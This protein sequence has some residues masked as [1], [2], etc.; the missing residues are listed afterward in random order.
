MKREGSIARTFDSTRRVMLLNHNDDSIREKAQALFGDV[1]SDRQGVVDYFKPA[2][3]LKGDPEKGRPLFTTTCA[4]CHKVGD[5]GRHVGADLTALSNRSP[6]AMLVAILD[7][8][9]AIEEKYVQYQVETSDGLFLTG[10]L[11]EE[12]ANAV[13]LLGAEGEPQTVLRDNLESFRS[14][15][16]SL[17]P[18]GL[19]EGLDH[20]AMADLLSFLLS[21]DASSVVT[22][23][24]DGSFHL[25]AAHAAS[26]GPSVV[27]QPDI[28]ALSWISHEDQIVWTARDVKAGRYAVFVD[29]AVAADYQGRPFILELGEEKIRGTVEYTRGLTSFRKRKFGNWVL[30]QDMAE[31]T[32]R[33]NHELPGPHMSLREICLAP[34][35]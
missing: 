24:Q 14:S 33:F 15:Q 7:P 18:D 32:I 16:L 1:Q 20:Q 28:A 22:A 12:S 10:V 4:S 8:S 5:I 30:N 13:T 9:R 17:M 34:A 6:E 35:E 29:A 19:E 11:T 23:A 31:L 2:L 3:T 25:T 26:S 21:S 27:F